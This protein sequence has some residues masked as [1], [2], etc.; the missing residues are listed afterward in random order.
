MIEWIEITVNQKDIT[1]ERD[2]YISYGK[3]CELV[4][5]SESDRPTVMYYAGPFRTGTITSDECAPL[6]RGAA[7]IVENKK[8]I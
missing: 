8:D 4:G 5:L 3:L 6:R 1:V 2:S 7:Y